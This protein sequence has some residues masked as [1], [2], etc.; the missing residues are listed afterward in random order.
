V[1]VPAPLL[2]ILEALSLL[3][4]FGAIRRADATLPERGGSG[5]P[6]TIQLWNNLAVWSIIALALLFVVSALI[7]WRTPRVVESPER[8]LT[9]PLRGL[10]GLSVSL[11]VLGLVGGYLL[12]LLFD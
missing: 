4:F 2:V 11:P 1:R 3:T 12:L 5:D 8:R 10:S 6:T 7:Y 9:Q